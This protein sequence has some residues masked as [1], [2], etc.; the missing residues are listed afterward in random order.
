ML[1]ITQEAIKLYV[2]EK[3]KKGE[4]ITIKDLSRAFNRHPD[5]IRGDLR[6]I[7]AQRNTFKDFIDKFDLGDIF[8]T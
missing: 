5:D 3:H 2:E 8:K 7:R 4:K 1:T 6:T